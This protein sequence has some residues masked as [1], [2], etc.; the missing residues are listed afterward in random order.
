M[1]EG[2]LGEGK[3]RGPLE[4]HLGEG[5]AGSPRGGQRAHLG[6]SGCQS[7]KTGETAAE[8]GEVA[9]SRASG[10]LGTSLLHQAL[11]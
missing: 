4:G 11:T 1:T 2:G 10:S 8:E 3:I 6:K 9:L 5:H 7:W